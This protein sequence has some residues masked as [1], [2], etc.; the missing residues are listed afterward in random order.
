MSHSETAN[1]DSSGRPIDP[2]IGHD[3]SIPGRNGHI[4]INTNKC[5]M[6]SNI[7][8]IK[9]TTNRNFHSLNKQ[10]KHA[11]ENNNMSEP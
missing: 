7:R 11:N 1:L 8:V 9:T 10:F 4:P 2:P 5:M 3:L 6:M